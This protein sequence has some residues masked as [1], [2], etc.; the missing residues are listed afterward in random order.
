MSGVHLRPP[1]NAIHPK[2]QLV[3]TS[4][5]ACTLLPLPWRIP[6]SF[7]VLKGQRCWRIILSIDLLC[8]I[9]FDSTIKMRFELWTV[10]IT[11]CSPS[12]LTNNW[13][14]SKH[15]YKTPLMAESVLRQ[16]K[17]ALSNRKLQ[18]A[19]LMFH[20]TTTGMALILM[21]LASISD[22]KSPH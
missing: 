6:F 19:L 4:S 17:P 13:R 7:S 21:Q 5:C 2:M 9:W 12:V 18:L 11:V 1:N 22:T 14:R 8:L 16:K 20:Y 10:W 3:L 15:S